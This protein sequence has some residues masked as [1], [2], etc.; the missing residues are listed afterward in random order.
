MSD[1]PVIDDALRR[2]ASPVSMRQSIRPLAKRLHKPRLVPLRRLFV[3]QFRV[4]QQIAQMQAELV[5]LLLYQTAAQPHQIAQNDLIRQQ[6]A[7][8]QR[9]EAD[10]ARMA[11]TDFATEPQQLVQIGLAQQQLAAINQQIDILA[12]QL[13]VAREQLLAAVEQLGI[14]R[15]QIE[16]AR[17][18]LTVAEEQRELQREILRVLTEPGAIGHV[19]VVIPQPD[20][21]PLRDWAPAPGPV[22]DAVGAITPELPGVINPLLDNLRGAFPFNLPGILPQ[23]A[24]TVGTGACPTF[25]FQNEFLGSHVI[26]MCDNPVE[27]W[28]STTGR[29]LILAFLTFMLGFALLDRAIRA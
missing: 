18:Q 11:Q 21:A 10:I 29:G 1:V 12:E 2:L 22:A 28:A 3:E 5:H 27:Q 13:G 23:G 16:V 15:E 20:V 17:Q 14:T 19:E 4:R 26:N 6:I 25:A 8:V 24:P 9:I 7:A